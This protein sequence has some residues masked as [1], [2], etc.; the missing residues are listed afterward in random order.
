MLLV[1]TYLAASMMYYLFSYN[2]SNPDK[3][4]TWNSALM[5]G[6]I[7]SATDPVAVVALLNTLGASKRIS[8]MIEGESLLNDGTAMVLF[9]VLLQI[10]EGQEEI[11]TSGILM[12][13]VRLSGGGVVLGLVGGV[14]MANVIARI[15]Y[16]SVL[17]INATVSISYLLF[18]IAESTALHV[19]GIIALVVMGLYMTNI[20]KTRISQGATHAIHHVWSYIG[21]I[22]ETV[23]FI[24]SGIIMGQKAWADNEIGTDD[25]IKLCGIYVVLHFIRFFCILMFWPCLRKMGYGMS[26][27]QVVLCTYAGLRGAVGLS[28]ALMVQ[29]SPHINPFVKDLV[30]LDVAGVALLTLLINASTTELLVKKLG[31]T[32]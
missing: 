9:L 22:A 21:F 23:I 24:V 30:L 15:K 18:Y 4:F 1:G 27:K 11:T 19:S 12:K 8:T 17:E 28:L 25:Y 26:F 32:A 6:S 31:L 16:N 10:V 3:V 2:D 20:G 29:T 7:I 14:V 5:Y 13:F